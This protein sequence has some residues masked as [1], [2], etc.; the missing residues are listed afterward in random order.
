MRP[1]LTDKMAVVIV[2][3]GLVAWLCTMGILWGW[4]YDTSGEITMRWLFMVAL[5]VTAALYKRH[6]IAH[7]TLRLIR[8]MRIFSRIPLEDS[9]GGNLGSSR[10]DVQKRTSLMAISIVTAVSCF[11]FSTIWIILARLVG[12]LIKSYFLFWDW[13]WSNIEN[14]F[15]FIGAIPVAAGLFAYFY[16]SKVVR[17]SSGRD[18]YAGCYRDWIWSAALGFFIFAL[19]WW[20]GAN[21]IVLVFSIAGVLL[22]GAFT[23]ISRMEMATHPR[24]AM[25]P[26]GPPAPQTQWMLTLLHAGLTLVLIAQC[27]MLSDIFSLSMTRRCLWLFMSLGL[28]GYFLGRVDRK[29][30]TLSSLQTTGAVIGLGAGLLGQATELI[31]CNYLKVGVGITVFFAIATQIA[32]ASLA[33]ELISHQRRTFA[34]S[35]GTIGGFLLAV[36]GGITGGI[37]IFGLLTWLPATGKIAG[38]IPIAMIIAGSYFGVKH[39]RKDDHRKPYIIWCSLLAVSFTWGLIDSC[40]K[41]AANIDGEVSIGSWLTSIVKD[42]PKAKTHVQNGV[43]PANAVKCNEIITRCLYEAREDKDGKIMEDGLFSHRRGKWWVVATDAA[44]MPHDTPYRFYAFGSNPQ[45]PHVA[46]KLKH[47]YPPLSYSCPDYLEYASLN[48]TAGLGCDFYDGIFLAPLPADHPQAWRVY[49]ERVM[50]LV[51]NLTESL[52]PD[53]TVSHGLVL[54]RTQTT[55]NHTRRALSVARTYYEV[56][57][58]GWAL[59][60]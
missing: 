1:V 7:L 2:L 9:F 15:L 33:A 55:Q 43:L 3:A 26:F 6:K 28:L 23:E 57:R 38:A 31:L 54:L 12:T 51:N 4:A 25:L 32:L 22:V 44:D 53:K 47:R 40:R 17:E 5:C 36:A 13:T 56:I 48:F 10:Q 41:A 60:A 35:G 49:N 16:A 52:N 11:I 27:R 19:S 59:V 37:T 18:V 45:P 46:K 39:L 30:K 8:G 42:T 21:L 34:V 24:K 14:F 50:R 58:S 29:G 20:F